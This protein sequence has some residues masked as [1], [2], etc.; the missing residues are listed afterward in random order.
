MKTQIPLVVILCIHAMII[1]PVICLSDT[2][3]LKD[4]RVI[5][6]E[7][8]WQEDDYYQYTMYGA[9]VGISKNKVESVVYSKVVE[10]SFQFDVWA[11]GSTVEKS[12]NVAERNDIPLHKSGII[13]ANKHFHPM[14]RKYSDARHF[15]YRTTLLGHFAKVELFFTPISRQLHTVNIQWPNQKT[16]DP[17]LTN[18]IISMISE[19]YG[20][21]NKRY[22][23]LFY[24]TTE[25]TTED[26]NRIEL[27]VSST[28]IYLNYLHTELMQMDYR[29]NETLKIQRIKAGSKKDKNK[30]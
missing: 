2:L 20:K 29:E 15:Y 27:N 12:F 10:P 1:I 23:K 26:G 16:K 21:Y 22:K 4:G 17:K 25:W 18:E 3:Y 9:T 13:S 19:K 7:S 11:F 30:F 24:S 6:S 5:E 28:A 8:V 14:V